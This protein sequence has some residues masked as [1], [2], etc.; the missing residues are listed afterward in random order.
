[1]SDKV[2]ENWRQ[3]FFYEW[4]TGDSSTAEGHL[5]NYDFLPAVFALIRKDYK[6]FYWPQ[7]KF[8]QLFHV[9]EDKYEEWD[10]INATSSKEAL[11]WMKERYAFLKNWSQ[12]GMA[13]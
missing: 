3:D 6:Y 7:V 9:E 8:E 13:V 2:P 1:L 12:S 4:N 5:F 10:S 11:A